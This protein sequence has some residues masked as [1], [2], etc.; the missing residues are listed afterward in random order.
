MIGSSIDPQVSAA[1]WTRP[2][3]KSAVMMPA[4]AAKNIVVTLS[5]L[6]W[7]IM[8]WKFTNIKHIHTHTHTISC[9][10]FPANKKK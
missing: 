10:R 2:D 8:K 9:V 7:R 4:K 5:N 1:Q 6:K 3:A